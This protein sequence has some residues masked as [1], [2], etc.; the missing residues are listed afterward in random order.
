MRLDLEIPEKSHDCIA[1]IE[2]FG[3]LQASLIGQGVFFIPTLLTDSR[4]GGARCLQT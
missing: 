3:F 2:T 1:L 4:E